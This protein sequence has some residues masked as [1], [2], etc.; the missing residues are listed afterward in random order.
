MRH[1]ILGLLITTISHAKEIALTFDDSP[2]GSSTHFETTTRTLTLI[3]KLKKL[4]VPSVMV[5]ANPCKRTDSS[6]VIRQLELYKQNGHLVGNHTCSHFR[7]DE[8]GFDKYTKDILEADKLLS[9]LFASQKYFRYPYLNDGND[10]TLRNKVREWLRKNQYR[11]GAVSI[12]NDDYIFSF[13]IN[14]AKNLNKKI[15]YNKV[16]SLFLDHILGSVEYYDNLAK[17]TLGYSPKHVLLLH[18]MDATVMFVDA[19]IVELRARGWKIIKAEE[20]FQDKLYQQTPSSIYSN[21]GIIAQISHDMTGIQHGYGA[22]KNLEA[23]LN[24]I[25]DLQ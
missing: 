25:L 19:L 4:N 6:E 22:S 7:L 23:E 15:D 24:K 20:A 9:P 10:Q 13:K 1:F 17:A 18:E 16:K 5:F 12:D 11:H 21:N 8:V 3:E 2:I 14:K